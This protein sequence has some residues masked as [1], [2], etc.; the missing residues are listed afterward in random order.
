MSFKSGEIDHDLEDRLAR[1]L[2]DIFIRAGVV[3][4]L[5]LL[6]HHFFSPF[7]TMMLWALILSVTLYPLHQRLANRLGG[8]QGRAATLI[9]VLGIGLIVMPTVMLASS[10]GDSIH[11]VAHGGVQI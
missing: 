8:K 9:V 7:L 2:L 1:R 3:L 5:V 4:G 10:F 6:C 11:H